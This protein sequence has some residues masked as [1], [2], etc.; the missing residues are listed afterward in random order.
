MESTYF[1]ECS[2]YLTLSFDT[3]TAF[4]KQGRY[5]FYPTVFHIF[6]SLIMKYDA[7]VNDNRIYSEE[8]MDQIEEFV[9]VKNY[10][11]NST[12]FSLE[13]TK[14]PSFRGT[15]QLKIKGPQM[16]CNLIHLLAKFGEYSG[17]GIKTAMGMGAMHIVQ[18]GEHR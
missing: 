4:K 15:L 5:Q 13:G 16:F 17:V 10:S 9:E 12:A 18:K 11:L 8:I 6:Q 3:P 2:R 7:V 14:I 1:G